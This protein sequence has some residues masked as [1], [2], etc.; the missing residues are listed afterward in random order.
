MFFL[1]I[2]TVSPFKMESSAEH[3][4]NQK[5]NN[6]WSKMSV[7]TDSNSKQIDY[8]QLASKISWAVNWLLLLIKIICLIYSSSKAIAASL[9][10]SAVD[11][12]SQGVLSLAE[13]YM[14]KYNPGNQIFLDLIDSSLSN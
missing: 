3:L 14:A 11:L 2:T 9:A 12:V 6:S 4:T 8:P 10:D 13:R 5:N 7:K 1:L